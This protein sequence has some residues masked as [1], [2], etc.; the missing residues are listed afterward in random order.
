MKQAPPALAAHPPHVRR[1]LRPVALNIQGY[2]A[3]AEVSPCS[4][5][6]PGYG[7]QVHV[8]MLGENHNVVDKQVK[9]GDATPADVERIAQRVK[10]RICKECGA[11]TI[12]IPNHSRNG[13]CAKCGLA[14]LRAQWAKEDVKREA[15]AAVEDRRQAER[16]F[17]FK[18]VAWVHPSHGGDDY[19]I[20]LY[21]ETVPTKMEMAKVLKARQS[22]VL[23]SYTT[24]EIHAPATRR[25]RRK[26]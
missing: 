18:T 2:P 22:A 21:T 6:Y 15:W 24:T 4:W 20:K 17:R 9:F 3:T 7:L 8:E 19:Q 11:P 26:S 23:D 12:A 1:L 5:M 14:A 25:P 13:M 16:G 10:L